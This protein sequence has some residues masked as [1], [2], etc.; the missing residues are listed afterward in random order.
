MNLYP[1]SQ[2]KHVPFGYCCGLTVVLLAAGPMRIGLVEHN[3]PF[4]SVIARS[5]SVSS[6]NLTNP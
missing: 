5:C 3:L 6:P 4:I 2:L 1:K